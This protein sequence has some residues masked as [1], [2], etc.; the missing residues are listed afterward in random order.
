MTLQVYLSIYILYLSRLPPQALNSFLG[1]MARTPKRAVCTLLLYC[2]VPC[3]CLCANFDMSLS[4]P[5]PP[6]LIFNI[7]WVVGLKIVNNE[8]QYEQIKP[9]SV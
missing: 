5:L 8:A 3:T 7:E 1:D 6:P 9:E 2:D 4:P